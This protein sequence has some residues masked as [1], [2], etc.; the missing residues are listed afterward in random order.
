MISDQHFEFRP[1]PAQQR[2]YMRFFHDPASEADACVIAGDIDVVGSDTA[3][4][5]QEICERENQV[6]YV[7]GN[8]EYYNG[9][10]TARVD[11]NLRKL[12]HRFPKLTILRAGEIV[13]FMGRRFLGDTM[14][15]RRTRQLEDTRHLINDSFKISS[16]RL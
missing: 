8:H 1:L 4:R 16:V 9:I 12:A 5:F 6:F 15:V 13:E 7:P 11:E 3:K 2:E 14:W 10:E